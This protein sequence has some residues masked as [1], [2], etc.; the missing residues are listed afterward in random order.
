[1]ADSSSAVPNLKGK[2]Y[3]DFKLDDKEWKRIALIHEVL[4][5]PANAQQSFSF[6]TSPTVWRII[7]TLEFLQDRWESIA[8]ISK[9][10]IMSDA[11]KSGLKNLQKWYRKMDDTDVYFVCLGESLPTL[12]TKT[13][14][15]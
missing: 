8:C 12:L 13:S 5:E 15:D 9:F 4:Q 1:L 14:Y 3:S 6:S 11:I 10:A 7:P 2:S